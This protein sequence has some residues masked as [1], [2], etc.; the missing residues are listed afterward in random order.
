MT[1]AVIT[2]NRTRHLGAVG[3]LLGLALAVLS[4]GT[5][6]ACPSLAA[7]GRV[8]GV[9]FYADEAGSIV[10]PEAQRQNHAV[11]APIL[12]MLLYVETALDAKDG[13]SP[14]TP[15]TGPWGL[16]DFRILDPAGY[17]LR[18]TGRAG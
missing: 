7:V 11:Q 14:R 18:I 17:Y 10:D 15:R 9:P 2:A 12:N 6:G 3:P 16:K 4:G 8:E 5:N 1:V 13:R